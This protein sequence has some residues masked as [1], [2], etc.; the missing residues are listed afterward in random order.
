M[1]KTKRATFALSEVTSVK[2]T[3]L[4]RL[5]SILLIFILL[6]FSIL[7]S[8]PTA[9]TSHQF[10]QQKTQDITETLSQPSTT[11]M[12]DSQPFT[13][14]MSKPFWIDTDNNSIADPLDQEINQKLLNNTHTDYTN[15]V[16]ALKTKPTIQDANLFTAS[17]GYLTTSPWT[18]AIYGFG[19]R[20]PYN[21]I[22][23]FAQSNPNVLLIEKNQPCHAQVAYA[24]K[25]VGARTYVWNTLA[26]QGDLNSSI[27]IVDT[28]VDDSHPDFTPGFGDQNFTKK[29]VGWNDQITPGTASPYDDN[30]HGSHVSG[31]AAGNGFFS[32]DESGYATATWGANLGRITDSGTY[33]VTGMMVNRTGT[34]NVK[35]KWTNTN[36]GGGAG[37]LTALPLYYGDKT[38]NHNTWTK[39]A[40]VSTPYRDTWY[41]LAY[42]VQST[43]SGGYDMYHLPMSLDS[44]AGELYVVFTMSWPYTPPADSFSAWT[45]IAPQAKL[46]GVKVLDYSGVGSS[47]GL[48]N[49][50]DWIIVNRQ[51]YHIVITSMSLGFGTEVSTVD[52]ALVNLV[53]SGVTTVVSAGNAGPGGNYIFT[54]GSV[55]E[56]IT[57][58]ATNQFDNI[59]DFSSQGG[60][61]RYTA[62]TTKPDIAA[63]GG[64]FFAVP[65]LSADSNDLDADGMWADTESNDAALMQGTSMSAPIVAGAAS[66]LVQAMGGFSNWQYT[67]MQALLP[68]MILLM[69]ATETYPNQREYYTS[70]SPTS[71][72]GG[73]DAHEGYGRLNLDVAAD[74]VLKTY[75]IGAVATE[76]LGKPP[77]L[78]DISV[79]G[80]KLAW[81]RKV[82]LNTA[83]K[84][85][86]TLHVPAGSDFDLYLY[87]S[88]GT[89]YGEPAIVAK[90]TTER[91]GGY[92]QIILTPP[93]NGTYYLVVKRA[94]AVTGAGTFTLE[95]D[96]TPNHDVAVVEV[97]PSATRVY[98]GNEINITVTVKNNG[99]NAESFNVTAFYNSTLIEMKTVSNLAAGATTTLNFT[100]NT[101]G[102]KPSNYTVKAEATLVQ[103]EHNTTDN[104]YTYDGFVYVKIPGDVN[105]D[106][107]VGNLDLLDFGISYGSIVGSTNWNSECDFNFDQIIN[108]LDLTALSKNY[109]KNI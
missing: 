100:W 43:P 76:T 11:S 107:A 8:L 28:G 72:R 30:G 44:G 27:A 48:L 64:S 73:K 101:V 51:T 106:G 109:G 54:P 46:V 66:I 79:L 29:I 61:S 105:G 81:A 15:V 6:I 92:E 23:K 50:I 49:A 86:F 69:T 5:P 21:Q 71:Q 3:H 97:Q 74:A 58:A 12:N 78:S 88:T 75:E 4:T 36:Q 45:G 83:G 17:N 53:N 95:S 40:E 24:A 32:V 87:N 13:P 31:L 37:K 98:K 85:N 59:A 57:V 35:V 14:F 94:T 90:N 60:I 41:T 52:A 91:T 82:Q 104:T 62:K 26:L 9:T 42:T 16:V 93:Y 19:G 47:E 55:D 20:L 96:F 25:Q 89:L 39:I 68:K 10:E 70:Y 77:S 63:P 67:R 102:V 65:L 84:Y 22:T 99:L 1:R 33:L 56:V 2:R 34:I 103:N 108:V 80:Q 38:L 7:L 18:H